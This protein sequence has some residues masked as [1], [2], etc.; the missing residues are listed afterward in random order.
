MITTPLLILVLAFLCPAAIGWK[1]RAD[2]AALLSSETVFCFW[3]GLFGLL[4]VAAS[5]VGHSNLYNGWRHLYFVYASV[6]VL[7]SA[8]LAWL[9]NRKQR[10]LRGLLAVA[11][12]ANLIYYAGF[13]AVNYPNEYAY[14]NVLAG[15][16]PEE[17]Y[18]ADYWLFSCQEALEAIMKQDPHATV[19]DM[20]QRNCVGLYWDQAAERIGGVAEDAK[21]YDWNARFHA[22]YILQNTSYWKLET[23]TYQEDDN[24]DE[25]TA[26]IAATANWTPLF[27]VKCGR[28]VLWKV[29]RNLLYSGPPKTGKQGWMPK[30]VRNL[31]LQFG[32]VA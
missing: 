19:A 22:A 31:P 28:T 25:V 23:M 8:S 16:H 10:W 2:H 11:V 32:K 18:D 6:I 14:F 13:I 30:F 9:W 3:I 26:W 4:P 27:E 29:Y 20:T 21:D 24:A 5:M 15:P 17:N 7:A 1:S 12:A